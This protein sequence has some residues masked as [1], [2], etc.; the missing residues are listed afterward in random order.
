MLTGS[1]RLKALFLCTGNSCRSQM[2]EGWTRAMKSGCG[3]I[4]GCA[5]KSARTPGR[6]PQ[7]WSGEADIILRP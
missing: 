4:D 5:M 2:A 6:C 3:R 7:R 1:G